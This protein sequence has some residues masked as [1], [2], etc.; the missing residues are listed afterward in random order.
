M[1]KRVHGEVAR[2]LPEAEEGSRGRLLGS[3]MEEEVK[4]STRC[5]R[6]TVRCLC[7]C[8]TLTIGRYGRGGECMCL[9]PEALALRF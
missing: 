9:L 8:E 3:F 7:V 5:V 4:L 1:E 6:L 2:G